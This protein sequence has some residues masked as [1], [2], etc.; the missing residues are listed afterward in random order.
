MSIQDYLS[1]SGKLWRTSL[2]DCI[3]RS[4]SCLH[5]QAVRSCHAPVPQTRILD[6][7]FLIAE[8]DVGQAVSLSIAVVPFEVIECAPRMECPDLGAVLYGARQ[9]REFRTKKVDT[10]RVRN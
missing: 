6:G 8:V 10:P 1:K 2:E 3:S 5:V 9:F 4:G 7:S